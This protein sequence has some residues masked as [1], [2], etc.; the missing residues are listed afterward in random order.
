MTHLPQYDSEQSFDLEE[1]GLN[2]SPPTAIDSS[3]LED[4]TICPSLFYHRH[5]L[6]L[7]PRGAEDG[8]GISWGSMWHNAMFL[9]YKDKDP[10][11]VLRYI[12]EAEWPGVLGEEDKKNRTQPRMMEL[13]V[14]YVERFSA[15]DEKE[16]ED[17]RREQYFE[18]HCEEDDDCP[19]GGCGLRWCGR[20]DRLRRRAG[21]E[22]VYVWDFKT[23]SWMRSNF[24]DELKH[25]FQIPGY[26]WAAM[27]IV[28]TQ[29]VGAIID[30]MHIKKN[31][32]DFG[33][34]E[35]RLT[36]TH[37]MEWLHNT[38]RLVAEIRRLCDDALERPEAWPKDWNRCHQ[39]YFR[40]CSFWAI[41]ST[42][43]ATPDVR[44]RLLS[45]D[46]V[47]DRW[48]PKDLMEEDLDA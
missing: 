36:K 9:Y 35:I 16:W 31:D 32:H 11:E 20:L 28:P 41:H 22:K 25:G 42:L 44:L 23:T 12:E 13:F 39:I 18:I 14:D 37:I 33:R 30:W 1:Y 45:E 48:D 17:I 34:H 46:Y 4:Y 6:G 15:L 21:T 5:V 27:H 3:M 40:T 2:A 43:P 8:A 7:K 47:E 29:V 24:F 10:H 26:V 19:F 38:K